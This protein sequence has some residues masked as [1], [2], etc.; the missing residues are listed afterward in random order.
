MIC[1]YYL[2]KLEADVIQFLSS[3]H[4]IKD[5]GEL[6][7]NV[8]R[9]V[10]VTETASLEILISLLYITPLDNPYLYKLLNIYIIH[11]SYLCNMNSCKMI[12]SVF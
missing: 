9:K 10:L 1:R 6:Q 2:L 8:K 4:T 5:T 11:Q 12:T 7:G 3:I